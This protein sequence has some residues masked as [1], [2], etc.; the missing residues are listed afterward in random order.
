[1]Q[2][3]RI[4]LLVEG[5]AENSGCVVLTQ[6]ACKRTR[7]HIPQ[8]ISTIS[9]LLFLNQEQEQNIKIRGKAA[10]IAYIQNQYSFL[11]ENNPAARAP[12][13]AK[14]AGIAAEP[15]ATPVTIGDVPA[16]ALAAQ[17]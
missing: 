9:C 17:H 10:A 8:C 14:P 7:A 5:F 12:L 6:E 1:M 4:T 11:E 16:A 2:N 15:R 3:E 13:V